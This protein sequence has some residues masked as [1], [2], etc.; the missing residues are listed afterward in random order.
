MPSDKEGIALVR[1]FLNESPR[2]LPPE[3]PPE[4][5]PVPPQRRQEGQGHM[6]GTLP[7][8][9]I[10]EFEQ[11][12]S[13]RPYVPY[14]AYLKRQAEELSARHKKLKIQP[15]QNLLSALSPQEMQ[16]ILSD[17]NFAKRVIS[18][19]GYKFKSSNLKA[20]REQIYKTH[21]EII[22]KDIKPL[23]EEQAGYFGNYPY[24]PREQQKAVWDEA[25]KRFSELENLPKQQE[26][27]LQ[28]SSRLAPLQ[29]GFHQAKTRLQG[30]RSNES[31][32]LAAREIAAAGETNV[33]RKIQPYL[34]KASETPQAFLDQYR[35]DYQPLIDNFRREAEK[36]FL[37]K[38]TP[39]INNQFAH[40]GAFYSG[41][42]QAALAKAKADREESIRNEVAKLLV[43]GQEEGMKN[44]HEH[45]AG[46]LKQA[47][48]SG[49]A[50]QHNQDARL[51]AAEQLRANAG[52]GQ[53]MEH[54]DVN[55]QVQMARVEQQQAQ[56]ELNVA[57]QEHAEERERPLRELGMKAALV[58]GLPFPNPQLSPAN[59]N[60]PPPNVYGLGAGMLGQMAGLAGQQ[61]HQQGFSDGGLVRRGYAGGDS[62]SRAAA[63]LA[64]LRKHVNETPEEAEM[65]QSAQAFKNHRANPMA[66]YLFAAG[67][68]Q[69]ANLGE[70]PMKTFGQG[71]QLGMQAYKAA[72]GENLSAQDKYNNLMGKINQ[73]KMDQHQLLAK[74]HLNQQQREDQERYHN[75]A[76]GESRRAHDMK[77]SVMESGL[78]KP[79]KVSATEKKLEHDA[80]KD[81]LRAI[82][83]KKELGELGGLIK[84]S[85]TGPW[86]AQA[87]RLIPQTKVDNK[88]ASITNKLILDMHQGMKNIPR[89]EEF[90]KRIESTKP[91]T[92][93]YEET[94]EAAIDMMNE[95]AND[96]LEHS[97]SALLS[98]GWTPEKIKKR[99]KIDVPEHLL[100]EESEEASQG[101]EFPEG[102]SGNMVPIIG[103]DGEEWMIPQGNVEAALQAGGKLAQ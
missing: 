11:A 46:T 79:V 74:Y 50:H 9:F 64:E 25:E 30:N 84:Q 60:P 12:S 19:Y 45:R 90:M 81:L 43:H 93:N 85:T 20:L 57:Q 58:H 38:D 23:A 13:G 71:S 40:Q 29:S 86:A 56:N 83:M 94:N 73:S 92:I 31:L 35:A 5:L 17:D 77:Y 48:I 96:V 4:P 27:L 62:V 44:Y 34:D 6:P 88:I 3:P 65:K 33:P 8:K 1:G 100:E 42:R 91:S 55:A 14:G 68:H 95:G 87:K 99:F 47:E 24:L 66:D 101:I 37:E 49:H 52:L 70:D 76:L 26:A 54:Q 32:R 61:Q 2:P 59:I 53:A 102:G 36:G 103:P 28:Q 75:A 63:Q 10:T 41:A 7:E 22:G 69:L 51:R 21:P 82:R 16:L 97:I 72:Q 18:A 78:G 98:S 67:S 89:S 39:R 80:Q 15:G